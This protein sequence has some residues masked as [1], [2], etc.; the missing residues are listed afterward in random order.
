[1]TLRGGG[2][3]QGVKIQPVPRGQLL[4]GVDSPVSCA[5]GNVR[6]G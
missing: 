4:S 1:M 5:K 2:P 3:G 6:G